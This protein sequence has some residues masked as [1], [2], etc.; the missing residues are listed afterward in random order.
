MIDVRLDREIETGAKAR[1]RYSTD[2]VT[3][4][5][6][7]EFRNSRWAFPIFEFEIDLEPGSPTFDEDL[8]ECIDLFHAAG[9]QADTFR[10]RHWRDY[11]GTDELLGLGDGVTTIFQLYRN[12]ARGAVTR[13]RKITRPVNG[14]VVIRV[15]GVGVSAVVDY[16]TGLVT[17]GAPGNGVE[18]RGDFEFDVPVRFADDQLEIAS[19]SDDLDQIETVTLQEVR[20]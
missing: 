13:R 11:E 20:E 8:Q 6:G 1:P 12:Y 2:V 3:T 19:L 15:G 17:I 4:D 9:G 18:V 10:F 7:Y 5:G 14:T 16:E